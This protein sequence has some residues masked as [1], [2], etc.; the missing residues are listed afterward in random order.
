MNRCSQHEVRELGQLL[1]IQRPYVRELEL[2]HA[3]GI[4][5]DGVLYIAP[6]GM[7]TDG[8][9]I[10]RFFWRILDP[11]MYSRLFMAAVIH[12]AAYGG[13]LRAIPLETGLAVHVTKPQADELLRI[14]GIWNRFPRWKAGTAC[15]VVKVF[16][17]RAWKTGHAQNCGIDLSSL[18]YSIPNV[19]FAA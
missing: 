10:P 16:G 11:P 1:L 6:A 12:D 17:G 13:I 8:A 5:V 7:L 18:D 19:R 15:L 2:A 9:S 14:V 3:W 4:E